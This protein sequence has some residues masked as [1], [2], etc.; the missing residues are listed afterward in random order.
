MV[1]GAFQFAVPTDVLVW[2]DDAVL[3]TTARPKSATFAVRCGACPNTSTFALFTSRWMTPE[4]WRNMSPRH[5]SAPRPQRSFQGR[6]RPSCSTSWR[7][8]CSASSCTRHRSGGCSHPPRSRVTFGCTSP[9]IASASL[10]NSKKVLS[11]S[12]CTRSVLT[13][14]VSPPLAHRMRR[15]FPKLPA[16]SNPLPAPSTS[17]SVA[18]LI[19]FSFDAR[20]AARCCS[21]PRTADWMSFVSSA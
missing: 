15:T 21:L 6:S 18:G 1:S 8:P 3:F 20:R 9:A 14:T 12:C 13:A 7:L 16:P 11:S 4:P 2:T 17:R 5:R 10:R 19:S